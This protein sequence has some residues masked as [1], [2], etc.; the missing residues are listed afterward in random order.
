MTIFTMNPL[1]LRVSLI[2]LACGAKLMAA[3]APSPSASTF[4]AVPGLASPAGQSERLSTS[5]EAPKANEDSPEQAR[6]AMIV[7]RTEPLVR[8]HFAERC[9]RPDVRIT[10]GVKLGD[11]APVDGWTGRW[12]MR[13]SAVVD[14][15]RPIDPRREDELRRDPNLSVRDI[16]RILARETF[17]RSEVFEY[18]VE[19]SKL[20]SKPEISLTLR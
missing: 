14:S 3:A 17:I 1:V 8:S 9:S 10:V 2:G 11:P 7:A 4:A 19:V 13:G 5:D 18:E 12:R 15:Y 6:N 16:D 20:D